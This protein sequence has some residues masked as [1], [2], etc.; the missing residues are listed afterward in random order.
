[1]PEHLFDR[2]AR[3]AHCLPFGAHLLDCAPGASPRTRF[4]FW[5]PACHS[6]QV[7]I[8]DASTTTLV[9]MA[10]TGNGW[11]EA[12]A[13]C[14][15]GTRYRYRLDGAANGAVADPASRFQP[16]DVGGPSEVVDPRAYVWQQTHWMGR[17][18]EEMVIYE[19]HVGALGG[20]AS[21][22]RR[23]PRLAELGVTAIEL[24]PLND[25]PGHRNWGYDGVLPF[26]PDSSYGRPDDLKALIDCAHGLGLAVLLDVVYNHFGPEG[27]HLP[28]YAPHFFRQD[29]TTPWGAAIDFRRQEV[30]EFF[31]QNA[32]Y[33]LDE[34]R[35][36]GLRLDAVH[37]IDDDDWLRELAERV[38]RS[39]EP[40]RHIHLVLE[41]ERNTA[42]LL[43][44]PFDAQWNDDAH[45]TLH[46]LLTGEHE[47]YY[48]A[49]ADRPIEKL[50]RVLAEG[51]AYQGEPSP[52]HDGAPRGE[53]S[54]HL[55]PSAFVMFLQNHD[56]IGNRAFGERL[57]TLCAPQALLAATALMLLSPQIPLLFMGEEAGSTQPFLYF[58]DYAGDLADAVREGRRREFARFSAF[59]DEERRA[60]IPDP[61][62]VQTFALSSLADDANCEPGSEPRERTVGES[63][64]WLHFYRSALAVRAKLIAP[65]IAHAR[66]LG[67][68][69]LPMASGRDANALLARWQLSDGQTLSIA[70]NL[71]PDALPFPA[72]P[73][74]MV[75]FETPPRTRDSVDAGELPAYA[76]IAW[77]TGDVNAYAL[78][79]DARIIEPREDDL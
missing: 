77:L 40:G 42:S 22:A 41:N 7:E 49:Y 10:A 34:Y 39:T 61:N 59:S 50:A 19:L 75:I 6:V 64:A 71:T 16:E 56:Q 8:E 24:M 31:C 44:G 29:K 17:P 76:C 3:Y 46:V 74:G 67:A 37:A 38:R 78:R 65:R 36:D 27:N 35:F 63:D 69:V 73:D 48:R 2:Q 66:A 4:R 28:R 58:T 72:R 79:H 70:L 54:A 32:R 20:Y 47:G 53:P 12:Q 14:G 51:F 45:N 1:M 62:A 68:I 52:I 26:A 5:A 57:R 21:V 23:L 25:F 11:F 15:A 60:R 43:R 55:P 30:R 13:D 33:W 18:W 9:D